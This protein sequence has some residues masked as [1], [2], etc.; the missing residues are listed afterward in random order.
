MK[1]QAGVRAQTLPFR[2]KNG[3]N[4]DARTRLPRPFYPFGRITTQPSS[5]I[6]RSAGR[7]NQASLFRRCSRRP[8]AKLTCGGRL[9]TA[10]E[11]R[12]CRRV[13]KGHC[14]HK[15][16]SRNHGRAPHRDIEDSTADSDSK[17]DQQ[18][19]N[20]FHGA[21]SQRS[22]REAIATETPQPRFRE[23]GTVRLMGADVLTVAL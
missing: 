20:E 13:A 5:L 7:C 3:P 10:I 2:L 1:Q 9:V 14:K 21:A 16:R 18:A 22:E 6:Q 23:D 11:N 15:K 12:I 4:G 19:K 17:A 8:T